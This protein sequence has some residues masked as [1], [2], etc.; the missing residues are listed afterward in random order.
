MDIFQ[1]HISVYD[2]VTDNTGTIMP[3][4]TFLFC[5]EYKDDILRLRAVFDKE[6]RN[7]LKRSLPQ[8]TISGVF[9]PTRAKNNLSQHSGLICVDIDAKDNPDILDWETLKQ[10]LSVLPQIAYCALSVSGKGLFLVI[11]LRYPEKHL[12][13]FRQLQID[14]RK[15]GIM[16]DSACSDITRLRCLSYDE[17]P[18]INENAT[19]YEG[20][21]VEK[22]K[23]KSFPTCF[24]YE[25]ENTSAEVAVCCRKIQQCG[26]DITASYDDW[27]KVGCAL[28]TL[29][30]NGRSL[31]H[32]CS[33]QNA[34]YNAAKTDK[35]FTDLLRRNY[36]Q[37]N[38]GT[39]FWMCKQY[40][41]TTKE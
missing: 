19:L 30:E 15:M 39:F 22:P 27:L 37:V 24:I 12:K 29:G 17:H 21:Y 3:L 40:G 9:S 28:T 7:A 18:I 41:I 16:I 34:K 26:I 2:G 36:Q 33:Q 11:P 23:H 25:R 14:F 38:I 6:K 1:T 32:I 5:K 10:D 4:G 13:Q 31:F 35:M 20:V 8:A